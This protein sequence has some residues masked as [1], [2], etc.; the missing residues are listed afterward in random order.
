M[1]DN[2]QSAV[3]DITSNITLDSID[4]FLPLPGAESVVTADED[5]EGGPEDD[6]ED[7]AE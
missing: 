4:D 1:E 2:K 7:A 5:D 3:Q 6:D